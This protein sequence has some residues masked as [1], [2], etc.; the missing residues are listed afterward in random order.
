MPLELQGKFLAQTADDLLKLGIEA[1]DCL[2]VHCSYRSL[3]LQNASPQDFIYTL[4]TLLGEEGTLVVPSH[5]YSFAGIPGMQPFNKETSLSMGMGI[6]SETLR[7]TPGALRSGNPTHSITAY[8]EHARLLTE[9]KEHATAAGLGS[10]YEDLYKLGAKVLLIGV[11][12]NRNTLVH[13]IEVA[14]RLP[15]N[16]IPY[17]DFW[18]SKALVERDGQVF[19]EDVPP[20]YPACSANFS[21]LDTFLDEIG[22]LR[23]GKVGQ[24]DCMLMKANE[25]VPAVAARL[26]KDPD[27]LLCRSISCEPCNLRRRR[28]H[29]LGLI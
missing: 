14:S 22:I 13:Y 19:E 2:K 28:L 23:Q 11:G 7:Q 29:D 20:V 27:F 21:V 9:N 10:S 1:G 24:A 15:Y 17:R 3:N 4:L 25:L 5:T 6:V 12:N 8:G 18:G 16:D 26:E